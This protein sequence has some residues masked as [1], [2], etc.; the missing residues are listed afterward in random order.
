[1]RKKVVKIVLVILALVVVTVV[2]CDLLV[3]LN[4]RHRTYDN[5]AD[6]PHNKVG[7]LLGTSPYTPQGE[8]N[9]YFDY[10]IDAAVTLIESGKVD[11]LLV[12][13]EKSGENYDETVCMRDSLV[14]RG[15]SADKI[16]LDPAGFRTLDSMVRAKEV[17]GN[18]TIT[19]ISQQFHNERAI[20]QAD[21]HGI[22]AIGYNAQ[23]V[24]IW[25][26]WLKIHGRELLARVKLFIDLMTDKQPRTMSAEKNISS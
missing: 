6:I 17:Y 19:I 20:Y 15:V 23:D 11:V 9:L 8:K 3:R 12:S 7:L 13:G 14:A 21:H 10:R 5:V 18:D 22:V 1:M 16:V 2:V 4:A 24:T 26:K 25:H